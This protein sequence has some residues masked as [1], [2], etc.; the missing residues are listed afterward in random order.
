M[1]QGMRF[2]SLLVQID[3]YLTDIDRSRLH[4]VIGD[5]IPKRLRDHP[6]IIDTLSLWETLFERGKIDNENFT[7]LIEAFEEIGCSRAAKRLRSLFTPSSR[8]ISR[9]I[10]NISLDYAKEIKQHQTPQSPP[11]FDY[12]AAFNEDDTIRCAGMYL[13]YWSESHIFSI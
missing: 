3:D 1:D 11:S 8:E 6:T 10:S 2:K 4:F 7:L 12:V 9:F 13:I 5:I